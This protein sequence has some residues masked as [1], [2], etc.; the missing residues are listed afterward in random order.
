RWIG[1]VAV[2]LEGPMASAVASPSTTWQLRAAL[3]V[4]VPLPT[5]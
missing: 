2:E 4:V 5:M 3:R 1:G